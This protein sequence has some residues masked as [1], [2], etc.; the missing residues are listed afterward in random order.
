VQ[1]VL[2]GALA[3]ALVVNAGLVLHHYAT[4]YPVEAARAF[5]YGVR[6]AMAYVSAHE[7]AYETVVLTNWIS[8]PHIFA[9]FFQQYDPRAFQEMRAPY[10]D[11]LSEKL[12]A[13]GEKYR[14]GDVD[15]LYAEIDHGLFVAR[16]HMLPDVEPLLVIPHPDGTPAF[17]IVSK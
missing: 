16:P 3:L 7:H 10:G 12:T 9:V 1:R 6:E 2:R 11:R 4:V 15:A 14:T 17:K 8:Q 5:E 13:W